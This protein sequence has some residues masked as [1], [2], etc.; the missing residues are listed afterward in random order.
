MNTIESQ[1]RNYYYRTWKYISKYIAFPEQLQLKKS[2]R[3]L[4]GLINFGELRKK[5]GS[6][7]DEKKGAK[8]Q[9]LVFT[10]HTTVR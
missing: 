7:V 2:S 9:E 5:V 8:L 4:Y 10:G 3:E 6:T 1:R